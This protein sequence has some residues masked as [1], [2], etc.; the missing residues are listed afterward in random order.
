MSERTREDPDAFP[1]V[2]RIP[3]FAYRS[4]AGVSPTFRCPFRLHL[5][6]P[7]MSRLIAQ[8]LLSMLLFPLAGVLYLLVFVVHD[9]AN[10]FGNEKVGFVLAGVVMWAFMALYWSALWRKAIA[11]TA[12]RKQRTLLAFLAAAMG[13]LITGFLC[14]P[15]HCSTST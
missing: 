3:V 13:G 5:R 2:R 1:E 12:Q 8:L 6:Q 11:W 10:G 7:P 4:D 9:E 15:N 14:A